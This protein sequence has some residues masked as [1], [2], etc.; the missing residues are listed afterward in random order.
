MVEA[1]IAA[2]TDELLYAERHGKPAFGLVLVP[3][4][5]KWHA[6]KRAEPEVVDRGPIAAFIEGN[7][8]VGP[9]VAK[10]A[11][12][13]AVEKAATHGLGMV[14]VRNHTCWLTAGYHPRRAAL[15]DLIGATW[16]VSVGIVAPHGATRPVFGTNPIGV[17]VPA[18]GGPIVVDMACTLGPATALRGPM[19][20]GI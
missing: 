4:I 3:H 2:C 19:E 5:L 1:E 6:R 20:P 8:T 14:G 9:L 16:S 12:D 11:M 18:A 7:D 15:A 17:A 13:L 10:V